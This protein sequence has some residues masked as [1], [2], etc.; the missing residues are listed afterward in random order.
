MTIS[1]LVMT[2]MDLF[3]CIKFC[4]RL[5]VPTKPLSTSIWKSPNPRISF[6]K[7]LKPVLPL[8]FSLSTFIL[9]IA[10]KQAEYKTF[11]FTEQSTN[12]TSLINPQ[13]TTIQTRFNP[14]PDFERVVVD[15]NSFAYY[16][17]HLPLKPSGSKVK[18]YNGQEKD[19]DA[20]IAVVNMDIGNKDLQQCADAVMRLR[21]EYFYQQHKYDSISFTLTNGFLANYTEWMKG[22]RIIVNGNKTSWQKTNA[23]SNTYNDFRNYMEVVFSYAGTLSLSKTLQSKSSK[24]VAIGDVFIKGGSPGHAV[25]VIDA[26]QNKNGEMMFM[27]AQS[28]MPA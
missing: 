21:G 10:C 14:P 28:Y 24:N 5:K 27:L 6:Q 12:N 19:D 17:R 7:T 15:S 4:N 8:L 26:A 25:I 13:G 11:A 22:N 18:Y 3:Y 9:F 2:S 20:Y 23:P 1:L 16:L